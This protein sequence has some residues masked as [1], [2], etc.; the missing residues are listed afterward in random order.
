LI[1]PKISSEKSNNFLQAVWRIKKDNLNE[2]N[3]ILIENNISYKLDESNRVKRVV[4][5][6]SKNRKIKKIRSTNLTLEYY[7]VSEVYEWMNHT[8]A[9]YSNIVELIEIGKSYLNKP[10]LV[11]KV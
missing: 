7:S 8:A 9:T 6:L 11:L 1:E 5:K 3:Q 2:L 10:M 4:N